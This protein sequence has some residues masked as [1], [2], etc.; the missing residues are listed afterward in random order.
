MTI[1]VP[2]RVQL[3]AATA[4]RIASIGSLCAANQRAARSFA[5]A[6]KKGKKEP[7][8]KAA[9]PDPRGRGSALDLRV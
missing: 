8:E 5:L 1:S 3:R 6:P 2:A 7:P 4:C 9:L